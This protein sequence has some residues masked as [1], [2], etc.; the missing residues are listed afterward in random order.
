MHRRRLL[1]GL[2]LALACGSPESTPPDAALAADAG[3]DL[4]AELGTD[5]ANP[6]AGPRAC[7]DA[8][9]ALPPGLTTL[10][11]HRGPAT[12]TYRALSFGNATL[13]GHLAARPVHESARFALA[14]GTR[15]HGLRV[16]W[17]ARPEDPDAPLTV[18]LHGDF[19]HNGFDFWAPAPLWSGSRCAGDAPLS[20]DAEDG[21]TT[22][23]FDAPVEVAQPGLVHVAHR[24]GPEG[25]AWWMD[26]VVASPE[27]SDPCAA[28]DDCDAAL[29]LPDVTSFQGTRYFNGLSVP[30]PFH[31]QVELLVEAPAPPA[32]TLFRPSAGAPTGARHV[33]FVDYD[34]DGWPD[35]LLGRVLWRNQGDG[36]FAD[37]SAALGLDAA[38]HATGGVFGDY[39]SDGCLDVFLFSESLD[40]PDT[41][42]HAVCANGVTTGFEVAADAGVV[43]RQEDNPCGD[44]RGHVTSP[45]AAAAWVDLDADGHLDLYVA[46]FNCWDDYT[47]YMDT[48]FQNRGDGTFVDV[49]GRLGFYT[50]RTPSRG[51]APIDADRDGDVDIFVHNYVLRRNLHYD[52]R[53]GRVVEVA[54][55]VGLA[56]QEVE[57]FYGH[58]IG[59]AWGDLDNDGD[60]DQV[61]AN[62]AHPRFFDFS[63]KTQVLLNDGTGRFTDLA[64]DWASPFGSPSGLR[65]Q[66]TH[67]VPVLFDAD[68][69]GVLDLAISATYD[70]RPTDFYLGAGDGS[71]RLASREAGIPLTNGWGMA[72]A[73]VDRDGDMDLYAG[74]LLV[75]EGA[76]GHWLQLGLV[77][78]EANRAAIG[79][80]VE[81]VA[82]GVARIRHVLG[83]TGMGGQD[84]LTLHFG[85][86]D[87]RVV[88]RITVTLPGGAELSYE[89][90]IEA[91]RRLW[92]VEGRAAP[93]EGWA[94][95][96]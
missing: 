50:D 32:A 62:L 48:V 69:D 13:A 4:G 91:D 24:T 51:V 14:G 87:A 34:A 73:D 23:V 38:P 33:S 29:N 7:D 78:T 47:H 42:M 94:R 39:D 71:F 85:L 67:S 3:P 31:Y 66:E 40:H 82:G 53:G 92:L 89:G 12:S 88:D 95:P 55:A 76:T 22:Y 63:D 58:T 81:V 9:G 96:D 70:G 18:G 75:N 44:P 27:A 8:V 86:G 60:F 6:D 1:P 5:A 15:I 36:T 17:A 10:A 64:G 19:G 68:Q 28:F 45:S 35:L 20:G 59:V 93:I 56:G 2:V 90:P 61:A 37:V 11:A 77:G 72:V 84:D 21:W 25:A 26:D 16:M 57:G 65:Y 54:P 41:L 30:I 79:A 43:D 80:T 52:N 46:N 49:S 74:E 83:G